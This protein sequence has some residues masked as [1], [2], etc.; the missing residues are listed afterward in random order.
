V[1]VRMC[2]MG[3]E[4]LVCRCCPARSACHFRDFVSQLRSP[5]LR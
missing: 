2:V 5:A 4:A 3:V 1:D